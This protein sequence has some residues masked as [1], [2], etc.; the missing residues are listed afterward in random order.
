MR[1]DFMTVNEAIKALVSYGLE[2]G[3]YK[4]EDKIYITNRLLE[5]LGEDSYDEPETN[6]TAD[7]EQILDEVIF[8]KN[9]NIVLQKT[10]DSKS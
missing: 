2:C 8:L 5:V 10:V 6:V 1:V 9:G 7:I 3:F 4:S